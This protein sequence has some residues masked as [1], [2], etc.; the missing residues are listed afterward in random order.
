MGNDHLSEDQWL[1]FL[2]K[3]QNVQN[4]VTNGEVIVEFNMFLLLY[5]NE[6]GPR[7]VES[8]IPFCFI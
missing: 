3:A 5:L 7:S 2:L 6:V 4:L 8:Y 1:C